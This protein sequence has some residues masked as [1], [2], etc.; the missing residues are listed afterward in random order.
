MKGCLML[1][2][3]PAKE[4]DTQ[5]IGLGGSSSFADNPHALPAATSLVFHI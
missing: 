3:L 5:V 2:N 1:E 4:W